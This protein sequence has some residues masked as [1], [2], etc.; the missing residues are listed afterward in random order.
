MRVVNL[1]NLSKKERKSGRRAEEG[2]SLTR[3]GVAYPIIS[4]TCNLGVE[5]IDET[6]SRTSR[7]VD[8][9]TEKIQRDNKYLIRMLLSRD[10]SA[11]IEM[12]A[13]A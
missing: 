7:A 4:A 1:N 5:G 10:N 8:V 2:N 13:T 11:T 9:S 3:A 12:A 6:R